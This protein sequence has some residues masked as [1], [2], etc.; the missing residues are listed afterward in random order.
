MRKDE[1]IDIVFE[2]AKHLRKAITT[3]EP[4]I[5]RETHQER[6][7]RDRGYI[8]FVL[9]AGLLIGTML[10]VGLLKWADLYL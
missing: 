6:K 10:A 9:F 1:Q 8:M 5:V 3:D 2:G 4:E 7:E